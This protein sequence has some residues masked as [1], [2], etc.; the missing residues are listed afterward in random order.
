MKDSNVVGIV[1]QVPVLNTVVE[2]AKIIGIP[3]ERIILLGDA[4]DPTGKFKHFSE[5]RSSVKSSLFNISSPL[6]PRLD[7]KKDTAFLVYSS[8]TTG[9]P[10]GVTLT[11]Y[12]IGANL[13][14]I[15]H[16]EL[17]NGLYHS[18]PPD[19]QGD[20]QVAILPFFHIYVSLYTSL[21]FKQNQEAYTMVRR[22]FRVSHCKAYIWEYRPSCCPSSISRSF[23]R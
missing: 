22:A 18:G 4:R 10:K 15:A 7:P 6:R 23:V 13:V 21:S 8:G 17:L 5:I 12:N 2:A 3:E 20:K 9:L 19:G 1:T 16:I 14:Q 11:H